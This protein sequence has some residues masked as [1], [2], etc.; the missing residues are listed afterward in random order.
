M[1]T[2]LSDAPH[3]AFLTG[4]S[5]PGRC[6]LSPVQEQ[7]LQ[8]LRPGLAPE[9]ELCQQNFPWSDSEQPWR[10]VPLWRASL[11]NGWQYLA[12]RCGRVPLSAASWLD[13]PRR[14]LLLVGSCGL[15][16]LDQLLRA[17]PQATWA[18][19]LRVVCYG[20]V[21]PR[22]PVQVQGCNLLGER[23]RMA[24][25]AGPSRRSMTG[26]SC[27]TVPCGHLDYLTQADSLR[28]LE[29]AVYGYRHWLLTPP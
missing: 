4:Q 28:A 11:A 20:G 1:T 21:G 17:R 5:D 12:A 24:R 6:A 16:L 3:I 19:R 2:A 9:I 18:E 23:D 25:F 29:Q 10:A 15:L 8:R 13:Q 27:Q 7:F 22:W 26:I 14:T